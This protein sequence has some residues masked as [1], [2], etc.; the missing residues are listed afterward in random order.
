MLIYPGP[1]QTDFI[2]QF[3]EGDN[4]S[5]HLNVMFPDEPQPAVPWDERNE[6]K[7]GTR[8]SLLRAERNAFGTFCSPPA[9]FALL[10]RR[11]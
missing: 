5:A 10:G 1:A 3:F 2:E 11:T 6:Y 7:C 4:L 9:A 8:R